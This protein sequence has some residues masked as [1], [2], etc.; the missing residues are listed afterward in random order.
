MLDMTVSL[1]VKKWLMGG[2]FERCARAHMSVSAAQIVASGDRRAGL[3]AGV[4]A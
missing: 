4:L 2:P 1:L 3:R